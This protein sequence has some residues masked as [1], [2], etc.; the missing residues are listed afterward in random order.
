[1]SMNHTKIMSTLRQN[2]TVAA[3]KAIKQ[4]PAEVT[5]LSVP[6]QCWTWTFRYMRDL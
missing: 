5:R 4:L 3:G 2:R 1:M 6:S